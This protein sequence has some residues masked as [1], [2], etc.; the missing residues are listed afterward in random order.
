MDAAAAE[1]LRSQFIQ[2][3]RSR[4]S[5]DDVVEK[6]EYELPQNRSEQVI[7]GRLKGGRSVCKPKRHYPK[8]IVTVNGAEGGFGDVLRR[9]TNLVVP[10]TEVNFG[11]NG[12][13]VVGSDMDVNGF[14]VGDKR[15]NEVW[16]LMVINQGMEE[17]Y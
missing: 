7:H 17:S 11:E 14:G 10:G 9:D 8:F 4:R 5:P 16:W 15:G 6:N 13:A 2:V 3:L 12:G 1:R